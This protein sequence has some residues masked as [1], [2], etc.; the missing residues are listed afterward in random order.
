M[1]RTPDPLCKR[2][3]RLAGLLLAFALGLASAPVEA[4]G[5]GVE[6]QGWAAT[7]PVPGDTVPG[8]TVPGDTVPGAPE[9]PF[10]PDTYGSPGAQALLE[11]A[12]QA[13]EE[14]VA[15][16]ESYE[17]RM[18]ERVY[19]GLR[20]PGFRRER[21]LFD[22]ERQAWIRWMASGE[23]VIQWEEA[24]RDVAIA[25]LTTAGDTAQA[26]QLAQ[27]L[28]R[29][30]PPPP[31][32]FRPGS[33]RIV[34]GGTWA[35]NPLADT[36]G[37][38]YRYH[39]GDTLRIHMP[40]ADRTVSLVEIRVEPRRSDSRLLAG[41]LWFDQASGRLARAGYRP[42]RPFD[43]ELD[44]PEDAED[45]PGIL[46]PIRLE[47]HHIT[48]DHAFFDFQWWIPNRFAFQGEGQFTRLGRFPV[49][50]EW[51]LDELEVNTAALPPDSIPVPEGWTLSR[52]ER[53]GPDGPVEVTVLVPPPAQLAARGLETRS[54][55]GPSAASGLSS[56]E[57]EELERDL[58]GLL[59]G[60]AG[61]PVRAHWGLREGL[62]RYNRIEGLSTGLAVEAP[63][64]P[65]TRA[66]V[67]GRLGVADLEPGLEVA[68]FRRPGRGEDRIEAY[69]RLSSSSDW[70]RP[71]HLGASASTLVLGREFAP[72]HRATGLEA[73]RMRDSSRWRSS[74]RLFAEAHRSARRGTNVHAR[75]AIWGDS[76]PANPRADRGWYAGA[77][78]SGSW[79]SGMD[80]RRP[81]LLV[82]G[83][84]EAAGGTQAYMRAWGTSA[85]RLPLA[86]SWSG[87]LEVGG[88]W[89]EGTLP[90]QR[91]FFPGGAR[92]YR[93]LRSGELASEAFWIGRAELARGMEAAR[94]A[95]FVDALG[96]GPRSGLFQV[97]PEVA[98]GAGASFLDGL[99]RVDL[100]RVLGSDGRTRL[101][102][103]LDALL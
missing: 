52:Q 40:G 2:V 58:R 33:D 92:I 101:T 25:G 39:D 42:A 95:V 77:D 13:L 68:L 94:L 98:V 47:I 1:I 45:V 76:L 36:A 12:R 80:P 15:G 17:A 73:I 91:H 102:A 30:A 99:L 3:P 20:A 55:T 14:A 46:L 50:L 82:E 18:R 61:L 53:E 69:R 28:G 89:S 44:G 79:Q 84:A 62:T 86:P 48:V 21:G 81:L 54:R 100:V 5:V 75:R 37:H 67:T 41:S 32:S 27:S 85:L 71:L 10:P 24:R 72:F 97:D 63:V 87:A 103:Y 88:G 43:L 64:G 74:V 34:F 19:V 90:A 38:H 70:I 83:A 49:E 56:R 7:A 8:E 23:H 22:Q 31:L 51:S 57:L 66:R 59:P 11:R 60:P 4:R 6:N 16:L 35:L 93:G 29:D 65:E 78:L 9:R 96:A 26:R